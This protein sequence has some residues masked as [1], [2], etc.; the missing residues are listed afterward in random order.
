[1]KMVQKNTLR[2]MMS[3]NL[4][5]VKVV[6]CRLVSV[7]IMVVSGVIMAALPLVNTEK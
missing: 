7:V 5:L 6:M 1:M 3:L 2:L 4:L